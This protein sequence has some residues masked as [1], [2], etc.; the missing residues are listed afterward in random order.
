MAQARVRPGLH[1][2]GML[3]FTGLD[4]GHATATK[5]VL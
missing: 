2:E 5:V 3:E 4:K 1:S